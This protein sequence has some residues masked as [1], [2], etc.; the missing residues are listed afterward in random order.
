MNSITVT[1]DLGESL[2]ME[3]A[4]PEYSGF[5]VSFIEGLGPVKASIAMSER[6]GI[7]GSLYNSARAES[8]NIVIKL[9]FMGPDIALNRRN[10]Y[11]YFPL[12]R[13][14]RLDVVAGTKEAYVYGYVESNEPDIFSSQAGCTISILC[15][16]SYLYDIDEVIT[17]FSSI[18]PSFEFPFSNE[19]LVTPL[20]EM[21]ELI[22]ETTKTVIYD[23]DAPIGMLIHIHANGS[24]SGVTITDVDT[25]ET[26]AIDSTTLIATVGS[27]ISEG[28]DFY[29]ST[30]NG[31]KY[32]KLYRGSTEYNI[33][34]CVN[35]LTW[36]QLEK[37]DNVYA[38]TATSGLQN[39][40]FEIRNDVAYEGM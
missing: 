17:V 22:A 29:I 6:S 34:N 25:L 18:T 27:D 28:D 21:S 24:A 4:R 26:L 38:F 19:S 5:A 32:A 20:L 31:N 7:D 2:T 35:P 1:N 30:V 37:G 36:F 3:L 39:L 23:G 33:L 8:R 9:V 12:K 13:R 11:K 14:I 15:P 10:T 16:D 40:E